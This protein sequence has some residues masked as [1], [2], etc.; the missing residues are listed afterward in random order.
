MAS[1]ADLPP[2]YRVVL[3]DIWGC[4]H[5]GVRTYPAAIDLLRAWRGQGRTVVLLTNAPRPSVRVR[6]HLAGMGVDEG[7]YDAIVSSGD[8]GCAHVCERFP[9]E[10]VGF[11]GTEPDREAVEEAGVR[12]AADGEGSVVVCMGY[13]PEQAHDAG[14]YDGRLAAM[15]E[16]G[17]LLLC[18]NPDRV[19][20]HGERLELCAGTIADRYIAMGGEV[21]WFGK[22][23]PPI[24]DH[25]LGLAA[26]RRGAPVDRAEVVAIGDGVA[27]DVAGAHGYGLDVV[28]VSGGI[29]AAR[30]ETAGEAAFLAEVRR[31]PGL[32]GVSPV[33]IVPRLA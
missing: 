29:E 6:R 11:I 4:V 21:R 13:E 15:R 20:V 30:I 28:F 31:R 33:A 12:V 16:R 2:R 24:Y 17:A 19:V 10:R 26:E 27:T 9:D 32:E 7:C 23:H 22:P 8:A 14:A 25:A 3:C 5:D 18:F 1:L